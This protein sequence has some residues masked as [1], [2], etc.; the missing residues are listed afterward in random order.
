MGMEALEVLGAC[1]VGIDVEGLAGLE[2]LEVG[3]LMEGEGEL[4]RIEELDGGEV[5]AEGGKVRERAFEFRD[6]GEEVG[7]ENDKAAFAEELG[8]AFEGGGKGRG[9]AGDGGL[10]G[11]EQQVELAG[12]VA[13]GDEV[14]DDVVEGD[15]ADGVALF[16]E[17]EGEGG[18]EGGGVGG[19]GVADGAEVHGAAAVEDEMAA[20][21]GFVLELLDVGAVGAGEDTPVDV[22]WIV[23]VGVLA[24]LG[25]LDGE[26]VIGGA[27]D[28]GPEALDDGAC[29][30][31]EAADGHEC[32]GVDVGRVQGK[33]MLGRGGLD[34]ALDEV[35]DAE[36]VGLGAVVEEDAMAKDG[37]GEGVEVLESHVGAAMEEGAGLGSEDEALGERGCRRPM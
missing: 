17:E 24:V 37:P 13:C 15:K 36:A 29:A 27:M 20:E 2:V 25:E 34:E 35:V 6:G 28:A 9:A 14:A 23:A 3:G 19:L 12:A 22:A 10:D 16:L 18:C 30:Q 33:E 11:V 5:V 4:G 32:A 21:V 26:A 7:E 1:D 31:L 8:G